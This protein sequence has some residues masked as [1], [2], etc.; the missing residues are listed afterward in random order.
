MTNLNYDGYDGVFDF[1]RF[2]YARF[3]IIVPAPLVGDAY[4]YFTPITFNTS[5]AFIYFTESTPAKVMFT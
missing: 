1:G 2:D 5:N 3:D 4:I